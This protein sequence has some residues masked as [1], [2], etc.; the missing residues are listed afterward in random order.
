MLSARA[1]EVIPEKNQEEEDE[2]VEKM[3]QDPDV[4][5]DV[6]LTQGIEKKYPIA[7]QIEVMYSIN[8]KFQRKHVGSVKVDHEKDDNAPLEDK[9]A[10]DSTDEEF[11]LQTSWV[12]IFEGILNDGTDNTDSLR[13][14]LIDNRPAWEFPEIDLSTRI[15]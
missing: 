3:Q 5:V 10:K 13:W 2:K 4:M 14:K 6:S 9:G 12:A 11:T 8:Q 1:H 7:A 15:R